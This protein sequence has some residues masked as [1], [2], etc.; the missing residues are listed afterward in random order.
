MSEPVILLTGMS[1]FSLLLIGLLLT[2]W[3]F[4]LLCRQDQ[5]QA[6]KVKVAADLRTNK[7]FVYVPGYSGA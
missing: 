1:V 7:S 3:E 6:S 2:M 5:Q 4:S